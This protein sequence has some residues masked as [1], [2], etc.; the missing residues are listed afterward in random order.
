M[1]KKI[2]ISYSLNANNKKCYFDNGIREYQLKKFLRTNQDTL[3]N[4]KPLVKKG[5]KVKK[6]Q[7]LVDEH[8]TDKGELAMG[9]NVLVAFMP[10][11]GYNFEDAI[12]VSERLV[13]EDVFTSIHIEEFELPV[14]DTRRGG[15]EIT[16]EVPYVS[17][18]A[19]RNLDERG[20]VIEGTKIQP[21]DIL[22]GKIVPKG[23]T[24]P[25]PEE[26]L[27]RQFW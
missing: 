11:R 19:V 3:I 15:E 21:G 17:E 26:K 1:Q 5:D 2:V 18:Q 20:I 24:E 27:L 13:K 22:V 25:T 9:K 7:A 6:G 14:R 16:R 12:V 4:Q 8:S 10:W 23:E